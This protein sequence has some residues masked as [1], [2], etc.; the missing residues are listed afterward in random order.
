MFTFADLIADAQVHA[1]AEND[2]ELAHELD[3]KFGRMLPVFGK[4]PAAEVTKQQI[5]DGLDSESIRRKWSDST[6]N[7]YHS[8]LSLVF[9]L[10]I[11]AGKLSTNPATGIRKKQ[12]DNQ[13]VR[14]LTP[15]EKARL[16]AVLQ[17]RNPEYAPVYLL[18]LHTGM[19]TSE[20]L[21]AQV[22][23]YDPAT[24]TMMIRQQK[25]RTAA[26]TRYVPMDPIAIAAYNRLAAGKKRG[27]LLCTNQQGGT[28]SETRYWFDPALDEA[29][30]EGFTWYSLRHTCFSRWVMAGVPLAAV[31]QYAGHSTIQM[32]MRYAHLQP[33]NNARAI[34]AAMSFYPAV[35]VPTDTRIDTS[36][37]G[38]SF[39]QATSGFE[40]PVRPL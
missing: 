16:T 36:T 33:E 10:A 29:H 15:A 34:A 2:P 5:R 20:Q 14:F 17:E 24:V 27:D 8:A 23:D 1:R 39:P 11:E 9:R 3:L 35:P 32:T 13:R 4:L 30:I 12:E 38:E 31:S 7:R 6:R 26:K 28:L 37:S 21:R 19:R 25:D 40:R 18:A 22:G